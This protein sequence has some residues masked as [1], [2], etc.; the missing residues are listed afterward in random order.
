MKNDDTP[1]LCLKCNKVK[2]L[3]EFYSRKDCKHGYRSHCKECMYLE[4]KKYREDNRSHLLRKARELR[5]KKRGSTMLSVAKNR[6]KRK[7]IDFDIT[8]KDIEHIPEICPV[9]GI[10]ME[11]QEDKASDNSPSLDRIDSSKGYIKG[12][13]QVISR[14]ANLLKNDATVAE[15]EA[16]YL[17]MKNRK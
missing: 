9:L 3:T 11:F 16:I 7:G 12:N 5:Y 4:S 17:Y 2:P 6:A 10:K 13:V 8:L 14:R 15:I 1:K